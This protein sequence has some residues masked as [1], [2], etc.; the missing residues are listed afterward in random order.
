MKILLI[1][2]YENINFDDVDRY[3][4]KK[5]DIFFKNLKIFNIQSYVLSKIT[6]ILPRI[7]SWGSNTDNKL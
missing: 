2:K 4:E 3:G 7:N 6:D 5:W 1:E